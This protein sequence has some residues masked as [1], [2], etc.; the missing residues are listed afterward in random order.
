MRYI[1]QLPHLIFTM[2]QIL[3]NILKDKRFYKALGVIVLIYLFYWFVDHYYLQG[4]VK[5]IEFQCVVCS[6]SVK[7]E[8]PQI[9][10]PTGQISPTPGVKQMNCNYYQKYIN[11]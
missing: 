3:V 4:P 2:F 7:Q 1:K 11:L 5:R 10:A 8:K 9:K 6:R